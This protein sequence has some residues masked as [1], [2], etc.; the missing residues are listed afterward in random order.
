MTTQQAVR[1]ITPLDAKALL[2]KDPAIQV[3]DTAPA[4]DWA[5]GHVP[6]AVNLPLLAIR[7]RAG[8]L[9]T[10]KPVIFVSEDGTQSAGAAGVATTLGFGEVYNIEG[11]TRAWITAGFEVEALM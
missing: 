1:S 8:E 11:G 9:T 2:E 7:S 4:P 10:E 6:G 3:V 5:G